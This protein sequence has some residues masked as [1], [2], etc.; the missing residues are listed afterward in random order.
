MIKFK[1]LN[2][3][4]NIISA[5]PINIRNYRIWSIAS[6]GKKTFDIIDVVIVIDHESAKTIVDAF[7][8]NQRPLAFITNTLSD[9]FG[10]TRKYIFWKNK[11]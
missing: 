1:V 3:D 11:N 6:F 8:D 7:V 9:D 2:N 5:R 4:I 10:T